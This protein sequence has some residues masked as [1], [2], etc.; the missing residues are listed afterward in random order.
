MQPSIVETDDVFLLPE[1]FDFVNCQLKR[2]Q[3]LGPEIVK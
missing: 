3:L 1:G 2:D